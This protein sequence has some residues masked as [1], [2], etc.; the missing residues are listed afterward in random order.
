MWKSS[1]EEN[2]E[3]PLSNVGFLEYN[4]LDGIP[5]PEKL[6]DF[7]HI[8]FM[9]L[10][11]D[12]KNWIKLIDETLRVCKSGGWIEIMNFDYSLINMGPTT[13]LLMNASGYWLL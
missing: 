7:V 12:E 6:M 10:C 1:I 3:N 8:R 11:F 2:D 9:G 13:K 4:L 5:F